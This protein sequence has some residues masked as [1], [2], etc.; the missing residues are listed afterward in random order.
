MSKL[1]IITLDKYCCDEKREMMEWR[2]THTY[3][4]KMW[5]GCW[6]EAHTENVCWYFGFDSN[7]QQQVKRFVVR[8]AV[9]QAFWI[10]CALLP[11]EQR[12]CRRRRRWRAT[13]MKAVTT[14]IHLS[15]ITHLSDWQTFEKYTRRHI[16]SHKQ[17]K[18]KKGRKEREKDC[19]KI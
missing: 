7:Q 2:R 9:R 8:Q 4:H 17:E 18:L 1:C 15:P 12:C 13:T 5:I 6:Q 19:M 3:G 16:C 14:P 10:K 11:L